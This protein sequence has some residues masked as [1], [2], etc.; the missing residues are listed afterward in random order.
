[1]KLLFTLIIFTLSLSSSADDFSDAVANYVDG[2]Y[3]TAYQLWQSLAEAGDA[4]AMF[5]L[6]ILFWE[7]KGVPR[8][9][10]S[11]IDWWQQAAA[12]NVSAAQYNL[13]LVH[14]LGEGAEQSLDQAIALARLAAEQGHDYASKRMLPVLEDELSRE[15]LTQIDEIRFAYIDAA[16]DEELATI[17]AGSNTAAPILGLLQAETPIRAISNDSLWSRIEPPGG[18][19]VWVSSR[20]VDIND[21]GATINGTGVRARIA[22]GTD[23]PSSVVGTFEAG[24][25]VEIVGSRDDWKQVR[26]P[27]SV[28][29]WIPTRNLMFIESKDEKW[30]QR[31]DESFN[32]R[33]AA[34]A[35]Q[36]I[37]EKLISS[38]NITTTKQI[39]DNGNTPPFRAAIVQT[40][41]AEVLG[42][43]NKNSPLLKLLTMGTPIRVIDEKDLWAKIEV[44]TGLYVWIF[45]EY[46]SEDNNG[47][48]INT[49]YVRARSEPSTESTSSVLGVLEKDAKVIFISRQ[50]E[51]IRVKARESVFGWTPIEQITILERVTSEWKKSWSEAQL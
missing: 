50:G 11:A 10:N 31:W 37:N 20:Y 6:G 43:H 25:R 21:E 9:R 46:L 42:M 32:E 17:Y 47:W 38:I 3:E 18:I 36:P 24:D 8:D 15:A 16:K 33:L 26:A 39:T 45:G 51:W 19:L 23:Q 30:Q 14:Y 22:P 13:S 28:S 34:Y 5:N 41:I 12:R 7:G 49:D 27:K 2:N 29:A 1:M 48:Y 4:G 44:P 40:K 35:E